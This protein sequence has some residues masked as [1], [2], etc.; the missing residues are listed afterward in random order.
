MSKEPFS[1]TG[2]DRP[3]VSSREISERSEGAA[4]QR[5][6][7]YLVE[8]IERLFTEIGNRLANSLQQTLGRLVNVQSRSVDVLEKLE[9]EQRYMRTQIERLT[10]ELT[11]LRRGKLPSPQIPR[12]RRAWTHR[13]RRLFV[14]PRPRIPK[15]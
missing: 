9:T 14:A 11:L 1:D 15:G 2:S 4:K 8:C 12:G 3:S 5:F 13:H 6:E 10:A 7:M